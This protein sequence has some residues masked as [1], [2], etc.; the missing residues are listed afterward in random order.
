MSEH[1]YSASWEG[2]IEKI[3]SYG[4]ALRA[5]MLSEARVDQRIAMIVRLAADWRADDSA[6]D[7]AA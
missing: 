3:N 2:F 1:T 6:R 7:A 4:P 5:A